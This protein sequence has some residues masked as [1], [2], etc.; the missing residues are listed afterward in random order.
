MAETAIK[1]ADTSVAAWKRNQSTYVYGRS[2]LD[3]ADQLAHDMEAK[4]G[5]GRLRLL[6][7]PDLRARFDSQRAKLNRA[8]WHGDLEDVKRE[9][10]R[11]CNAWHVLDEQAEAG[12]APRLSPDVWEVALPNGAVAALVKN[13][14]H[15]H[16]VVAQGRRVDV[17]TL[18][19]IANLISGFPEIV[20]VK[21]S[22]PG[23]E[24]VRVGPIT[25]PLQS[26]EFDDEIPF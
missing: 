23:A 13:A 4:W 12:G 26:E 22:F 1:P 9:A 19:E 11:M 5:V 25:D 2:F 8:I 18:D 24:V 7:D 17:F 14:A 15:A 16:A 10:G 3:G 6:V 21:A 20:K